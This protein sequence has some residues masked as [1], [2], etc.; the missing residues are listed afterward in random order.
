MICDGRLNDVRVRYLSDIGVLVANNVVTVAPSE[1][2]T[3]VFEMALQQ[4]VPD[5]SPIFFSMILSNLLVRND[6][7]RKESL[8]QVPQIIMIICSVRQISL[9]LHHVILVPFFL[10]LL[11]KSLFGFLDSS[12]SLY[13]H[14][15]NLT[16]SERIGDV[17]LDW[18][19]FGAAVFHLGRRV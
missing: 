7:T 10:F 13:S 11:T 5:K 19:R 4:P 6:P 3:F 14:V 12:G 9:I 1:S 18:S 8:L 16:G 2:L 17:F 15:I